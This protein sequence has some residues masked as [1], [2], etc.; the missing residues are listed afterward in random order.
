MTERG[1]LTD[2]TQNPDRPLVE[3]SPRCAPGGRSVPTVE[4]TA[5]ATT[6]PDR[7]LTP[8]E[9][10]AKFFLDNADRSANHANDELIEALLERARPRPHR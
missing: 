1:Q 8:A 4:D 10:L 3:P 6:E 9:A 5:E 2:P 7:P